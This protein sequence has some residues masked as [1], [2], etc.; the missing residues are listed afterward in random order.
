MLSQA[1]STHNKRK[2]CGLIFI[3]LE[4]ENSAQ[5]RPIAGGGNEYFVFLKSPRA[6]TLKIKLSAPKVTFRVRSVKCT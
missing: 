3:D 2:W 4:S 6:P 5:G 1:A